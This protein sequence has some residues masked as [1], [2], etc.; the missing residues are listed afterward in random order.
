MKVTEQ[1]ETN[2]HGVLFLE[3]AAVQPATTSLRSKPRGRARIARTELAR[4]M[5]IPPE[6]FAIL[7][8]DAPLPEGGIEAL[9]SRTNLN[10]AAC[11]AMIDREFEQCASLEEFKCFLGSLDEF[12]Q[13]TLRE[14]YFDE[15]CDRHIDDSTYI[16]L[17]ELSKLA[18]YGCVRN[19]KRL[20]RLIG[21]IEVHED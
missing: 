12:R 5:S 15:W 17:I 13:L 14:R 6:A 18:P 9:L 4:R 2:G 3:R 21:E 19:A 20:L 10:K 16:E 8:E 7:Y 11:A 1:T